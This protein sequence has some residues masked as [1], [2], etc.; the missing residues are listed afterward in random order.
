MYLEFVSR[1]AQEMQTALMV[2]SAAP[3]A[4]AIFVLHQIQLALIKG[5][6]TVLERLFP[7]GITAIIGT[8]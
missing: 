5:G 6:G 8:E 1:I 3:M 2:G 4:V 7:L